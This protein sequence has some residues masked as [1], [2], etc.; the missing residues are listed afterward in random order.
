MLSKVYKISILGASI[1]LASC[2]LFQKEQIPLEG[3]R[4]GVLEGQNSLYSDYAVSGYSIELPPMV[5][6]NGWYQSGGNSEHRLTHLM[7]GSNFKKKWSASFGS[8]ISRGDYLMASPVVANGVVFTIDADA[9]IRAF[10]LDNGERIW[11][12]KI[13]P[14]LKTQNDVSM[15]GAGLAVSAMQKTVFATTG[16]GMVYAFDMQTGKRI[17][18][19]DAEAPIRIAPTIGGGHVFVQTVDNALIALNA[20]SGEEAWRYKTS[21]EQTVIVGGASP[22]YNMEKDV[23]IAAFSNGE[24]S[25]FKTSTGS[26]LWDYFLAPKVRTNSLSSINA[27]KSNPI[28]DGEVVY[29]AGTNNILAA[30]DLRN[31]MKL[32]EKE[33]GTSNPMFLVRNYLFV[34]N[35]NFELVALN[36]Q[37]GNIYWASKLSSGKDLNEKVGAFAAG[38]ILVNNRLIVATSNGYAFA[39]SPYDGKII[40]S[41]ELDN[42]VEVSPIVADG[43]II[44]TTN[45]A[46]LFVYE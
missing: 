37:N 6:N 5:K 26:P 35:N 33:I 24:L 7:A 28:I 36:A 23:V 42:G 8:G 45:N 31:G 40:A 21:N 25:A 4:I 38:P 12:K 22:A 29:A 30:I 3:E 43:N 2:S 11:K 17:W 20:V 39:V 10:R 14:A 18:K 41:T 27:I 34:L 15:K 19:F 9:E 44:L 1:I 46:K 32:W 16:F 13:K